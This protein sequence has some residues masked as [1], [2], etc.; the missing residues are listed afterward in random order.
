MEQLVFDIVFWGVFVGGGSIFVIIC[1]IMGIRQYKRE[2][3]KQKNN[4]TNKNNN[5]T[6]EPKYTINKTR[7][8]V[9][10]Q[11]CCVKM[12]GTKTPKTIREFSIAFEVKDGDIVKIN[13]PKEMYDGFEEGQIGILTTL[14][15]ELYSFEPEECS[16]IN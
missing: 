2:K 12:V 10:E 11:I 1:F 7:A 9:I 3:T 4:H 13:V 8:T 16:T 15:G 6:I 14:D 5:E